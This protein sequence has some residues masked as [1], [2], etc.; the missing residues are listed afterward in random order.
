MEN[1]CNDFDSGENIKLTENSLLL[2]FG[3]HKTYT[4]RAG[5]EIEMA[6]LLWISNWWYPNGQRKWLTFTLR[7]QK[8]IECSNNGCHFYVFRGIINFY[9]D[10]KENVS[11]P[12]WRCSSSYS[13]C[14][15][16]RVCKFTVSIHAVLMCSAATPTWSNSHKPHDFHF[17]LNSRSPPQSTLYK[18]NTRVGYKVVATLL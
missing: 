2:H 12:Q 5:I 6:S 14:P 1:E 11:T 9:T 18:L 10:C 4:D 13:H 17:L 15:V 7:F 3:H 16:R 8:K